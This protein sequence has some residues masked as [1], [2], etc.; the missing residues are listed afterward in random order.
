MTPFESGNDFVGVWAEEIRGN[1]TP[2]GTPTK[3]NPGQ[4]AESSRRAK[5]TMDDYKQR[6]RRS[7]DPKYLFGIPGI[8]A[9]VQT[10]APSAV[11]SS[12][13]STHTGN[14]SGWLEA[15]ISTSKASSLPLARSTSCAAF[16][17][18]PPSSTP[19]HH[20]V[21]DLQMTLSFD[22]PPCVHLQDANSETVS[23]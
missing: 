9:A 16:P 10:R 23:L 21:K 18:S 4:E 14:T 3:G 17:T 7:H 2:S 19:W 5:I 13:A 20:Q 11:S 8:S 22:K 15:A 12:K 1:V 6:Q